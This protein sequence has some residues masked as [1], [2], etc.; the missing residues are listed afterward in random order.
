[1]ADFVSIDLKGLEEVQV[2][3]QNTAVVDRTT[4]QNVG[5]LAHAD[6]IKNFAESGR[7]K[8]A[9]LADST[10][11]RRRHGKKTEHGTKPLMDT[12]MLRNSIG[13]TATK[14]SVEIGPSANYGKFHEL[15][16]TVGKLFK[17]TVLPRPFLT[18]QPLTL[19]RMIDI[20]AG[21]KD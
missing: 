2:W 21:R 16:F 11:E 8:W 6:I 15:G 18:L 12:G 4:M 20:I 7:P 3:L 17:Y 1:M 5:V 13:F 14:N 10:I 19:E 9:P